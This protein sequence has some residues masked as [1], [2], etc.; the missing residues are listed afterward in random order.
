M[1]T[2]DYLMDLLKFSV[3]RRAADPKLGDSDTWAIRRIAELAKGGEK[4]TAMLVRNANGS[5]FYIMVKRAS[6]YIEK[7]TDRG[8]E[9]YDC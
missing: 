3:E 2:S 1:S 4:A 7:M 9:E 5:E 6:G 8:I